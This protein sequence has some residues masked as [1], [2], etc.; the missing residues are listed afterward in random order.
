M[1]SSAFEKLLSDAAKKTL[2]DIFARDP[3]R[4]VTLIRAAAAHFTDDEV[5]LFE[6]FACDPSFRTFMRPRMRISHLRFEKTMERLFR[7]ITSGI[8]PALVAMIAKAMST[9]NYRSIERSFF[10]VPVDMHSYELFEEGFIRVGEQ[11]PDLLEEF[12]LFYASEEYAIF[13]GT[14]RQYDALYQDLL[15]RLVDLLLGS[16]LSA[17]VR[18]CASRLS[19]DYLGAFVLISHEMNKSAEF[20]G[21]VFKVFSTLRDDD[22]F[23]DYVRSVHTRYGAVLAREDG[24]GT[25]IFLRLVS[26]WEFALE[27]TREGIIPFRQ[28]LRRYGSTRS[29]FESFVWD[30]VFSLAPPKAAR[31]VGILVSATFDSLQGYYSNDSPTIKFLVSNIIA[32]IAEMEIRGLAN[33]L[34]QVVL[35]LILGFKLNRNFIRRRGEFYSWLKSQTGSLRLEMEVIRFM[36]FEYIFISLG[37]VNA[38]REVSMTKFCDRNHQYFC[39]VLDGSYASLNRNGVKSRNELFPKLL[40]MLRTVVWEPAYARFPD[41]EYSLEQLRSVAESTD[42]EDEVLA[43]LEKVEPEN[44]PWYCGSVLEAF[45]REPETLEEALRPDYWYR[46][47]LPEAAT[48]CY[49]IMLPLIGTIRIAESEGQTAHTDGKSIFLPKYINYF[50]DPLDPLIDNR[51]LTT[52]IALTLHETG[53]ILGGSYHFNIINYLNKLEKPELFKEIWNC[54][55]DFRIEEFMVRINAHAQVRE[56]FCIMNSYLSAGLAAAVLPLASRMILYVADQAAGYHEAISAIPQYRLQLDTLFER[57]ANTGRFADLRTMADYGV[58]RLKHLDIGNPL[59]VYPLAREFYEVMKHWSDADLVALRPKRELYQWVVDPDSDGGVGG[60]PAVG[61]AT[62]PLSREELDRMYRDYNENPR[63]FL[64]AMGLPVFTSLVPGDDGEGREERP[65]PGRRKPTGDA[66]ES[67]MSDILSVG[68]DPDYRSKGTVDQSTRTKVDDGLAQRQVSRKPGDRDGKPVKK[69]GGRRKKRD[70]RGNKKYVYS[71]DPKTGSRTRLSEITE[72]TVRGVDRAFMKKFRK[73]EY[74]GSLVHQMLARILPA[75]EDEHDTSR[76]EGD[77]DLELLVEVLSDRRSIQ[78]SPEIFEILRE[79]RRSLEVMIGLDISGSTMMPIS[80]EIDSDAVIDIEKAFAIIFGRA[81]NLLT[82]RVGVYAFNS[83]TSTNV[84]RAESIDSI[85]MF[86]ADAANRDGD[87]I[88]YVGNMLAKSDAEEKYFFL[89][90]DGQPNSDNY[91]GKEALD[92]TLIA[93]R[94]TVNAGIKL[95]YFNFDAVRGEYFALFQKEST[96]ARYF[97]TPSEILAVIPRMVA[98]V[99]SS[100]R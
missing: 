17:K 88:R 48:Y 30:V 72:Y 71:I 62:R 25:A 49:G 93:M 94:E 16:G 65:G 79:N 82:D 4:R 92:D 57:K 86:R 91:F 35:K 68:C 50:K 90:S 56:I 95:I 98:S 78:E 23:F 58:E 31:A 61:S 47:N 9:D 18:H 8:D 46:V 52:Y 53:H 99:A 85:S 84:Y 34:Y 33:P 54:F 41:G 28:F 44:L 70:R 40:E 21:M 51:N 81:M 80:Q 87:F 24:S 32:A 89:L 20:L 36:F 59:A 7:R 22:V 19:S 74:L 15:A 42:C 3:D 96:F 39:E 73:W 43:A 14:Y 27:G 64:E 69:A 83:A 13:R 55:E 5:G 67:F 11:N 66:R 29:E 37:F 63:A 10:K 77:M 38:E 97:K 2:S 12:C 26:V 100:I 6:A 1:K 75:L 76:F 60:R 45:R